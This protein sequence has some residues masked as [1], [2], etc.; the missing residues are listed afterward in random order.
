MNSKETK[1]K[2]KAKQR[3]K[4][5]LGHEGSN[6]RELVQ[7]ERERARESMNEKGGEWIQKK[8]C[9]CVWSLRRKEGR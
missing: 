3:R 2:T 1:N 6:G 8:R 7:P 9:A 4:G 5:E